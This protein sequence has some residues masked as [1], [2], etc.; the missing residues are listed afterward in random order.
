TSGHALFALCLYGI[1]ASLTA[2][3]TPRV[4]VRVVIWMFAV[5]LIAAI[6]FSRIYLGAHYPTDVIAG[7]AAGF[8]WVVA[9]S[10]GD[11]VHRLRVRL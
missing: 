8:I 9:V 6:G 2:G 4:G 11:R 3:R 5:I 1:L 10:F 7:Y